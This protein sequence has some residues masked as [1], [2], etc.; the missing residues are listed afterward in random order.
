MTERKAKARALAKQVPYVDDRKKG[1]GNSNGK[2][3]PLR[4]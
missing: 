3:G 4:G 2:A 1:K